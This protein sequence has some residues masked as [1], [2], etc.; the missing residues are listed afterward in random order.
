[1]AVGLIAGSCAR[2]PVLPGC[3]RLV[4]VMFRREML[5]QPVEAQR[6]P[7]SGIMPQGPGEGTCALGACETFGC[8]MQ[9][10]PTAWCG[11]GR[12]GHDGPVGA[13]ERPCDGPETHTLHA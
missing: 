1:M 10:R 8:G 3:D 13:R 7:D 2:A 6:P 11:A 12:V 9:V 5:P 4:P